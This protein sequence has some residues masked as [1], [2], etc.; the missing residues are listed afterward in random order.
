[1]RWKGR[2]S[3]LRPWR[4]PRPDRLLGVLEHLDGRRQAAPPPRAEAA[5]ADKGPFGP[6]AC[7]ES[8]SRSAQPLCR[9]R[10][11]RYN[12]ALVRGTWSSSW[13]ATRLRKTSSGTPA[14]QRNGSRRS[15][16]A[17]GDWGP[18]S[19]AGPPGSAGVRLLSVSRAQAY[20]ST[21]RTNDAP[22]PNGGTPSLRLEN[23]EV[24]VS[25]ARSSA[26]TRRR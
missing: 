13:Q 17:T 7:G 10:H 23:P 19:S 2:R 4:R 8:G 21:D 9:K 22:R 18:W 14:Q 5:T 24:I 11:G 3:P 1:M 6:G 20:G 25:L 26:P 16:W 15:P 12:V